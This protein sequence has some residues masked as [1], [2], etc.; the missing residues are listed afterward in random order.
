MTNM[1]VEIPSRGSCP[2]GLSSSARTTLPIVFVV[3]A[4]ECVRQSLEQLMTTTGFDVEGC[5]SGEEFLSL[6]R[7]AVAC[8]L[9][10]LDVSTGANGLELQRQVG[11]T[12]DMPIV[13]ITGRPDV[14]VTVQ[15]MKAGAV[16]V[17][18]EPVN[19]QQLLGAVEVA[20]ELSRAAMRRDAAMRPLRDC[21]ASL[22][23]REREVMGLVVS[24]APRPGLADRARMTVTGA[25]GSVSFAESTDTSV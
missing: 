16:D 8:C 22:T 20:I 7:P 15:A 3:A 14:G 12:M 4:D 18:A 5:V 9:L 21:Y 2:G 1:F 11:A 19:P 13:F 23:P 24:R 25:H 6:A 17:L 10:L